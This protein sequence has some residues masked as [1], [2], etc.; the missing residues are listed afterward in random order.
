MEKN[1]EFNVKMQICWKWS[2]YSGVHRTIPD[3]SQNCSGVSMEP[4][5]VFHGFST[6]IYMESVRLSESIPG[7]LSEYSG[8]FSLESPEKLQPVYVQF[9]LITTT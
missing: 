8:D 5:Q 2:E 3:C 6:L 9:K 7:K 4:F 1:K